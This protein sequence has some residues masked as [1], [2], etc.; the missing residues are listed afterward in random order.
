M[1]KAKK[2]TLRKIHYL[3]TITKNKQHT[4]SLKDSSAN[5]KNKTFSFLPYFILLTAAMSLQYRNLLRTC[6][7]L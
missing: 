2:C 3:K 5:I 6:S 4:L 7:R 1:L